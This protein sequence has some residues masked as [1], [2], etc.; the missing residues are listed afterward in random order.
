MCLNCSLDEERTDWDQVWDLKDGVITEKVISPSDFGLPSNALSTVVGGTPAENASTLI[1]LLDNQLETT[2][3]IEN[4]VVINT[5]ALLLVAGKVD[6]L[7]EG[8]CMA[9]ESIRGGG[10]KT[11]LA[12]FREASQKSVLK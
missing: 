6:D 7:I 1:A 2:N 8:V 5:A 9:R 11:A 10:A 12:R 3:P 4:F